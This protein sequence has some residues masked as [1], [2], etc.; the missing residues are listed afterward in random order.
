MSIV[1]YAQNFEDVMLWRALGHIPNGAYIDVGAQ[2]PVLDSVS[3]AFYE[4]GWRGIHIEPTSAYAALIQAARPDEIVMQVALND[5]PGILTFFEILES[6][7]ST[8]DASIAQ[9]HQSCG[10]TVV[11][12]SVPCITMDNVFDS[13]NTRDVHWLKI[14]VEGMEKEVLEGWEKSTI[15]PWIVLIES[16][17]PNSQTQTHEKWEHLILKKG[18]IEVYFDGLNKYY[19]SVN[20]PELILSFSTPPNIFDSFTLAK[21]SPYNR[22]CQELLN[23][24]DLRMNEL[25]KS[26]QMEIADLRSSLAQDLTLKNITNEDS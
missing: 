16:T 13:I 20:K 10:Y 5:S 17:Y 24:C 22:L 18:Y 11:E 25:V 9:Y 26:S 21:T 8:G 7:L 15:R 2:H 4:N 23:Q 12:I 14:D 19:V 1:S 3:N 6:G